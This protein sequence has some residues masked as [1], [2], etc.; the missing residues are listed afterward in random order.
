MDLDVWFNLHINQIF[1]N[2][3]HKNSFLLS[4]VVTRCYTFRLLL[5]VFHG[6]LSIKQFLFSC[7]HLIPHFDWFRQITTNIYSSFHVIRNKYQSTLNNFSGQPFSISI[8]KHSCRLYQMFV[9]FKSTEASYRYILSYTY[10][11]YSCL[12]EKNRIRCN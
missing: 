12:A 11:S 3:V 5:P 9:F 1:S 8:P 4:R 7:L 10:S 6:I 2:N